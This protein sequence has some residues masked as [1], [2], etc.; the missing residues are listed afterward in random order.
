[1]TPVELREC[2]EEADRRLKVKDGHSYLTIL[3]TRCQYCGRSPKQKGRCAGWFQTFLDQ[4]DSV[5]RE[6]GLVK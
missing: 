6:R 3:K 2:Y 4:L 1:M 5:L